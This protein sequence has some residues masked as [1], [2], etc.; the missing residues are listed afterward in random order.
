MPQS[1]PTRTTYSIVRNQTVV[2]FVNNGPIIRNPDKDLL[3]VASTYYINCCIKY[4]GWLWSD[5]HVD[6][7]ASQSFPF[8]G[9]FCGHY[10]C[11]SFIKYFQEPTRFELSGQERDGVPDDFC[12]GVLTVEGGNAT[13]TIHKKKHFGALHVL[14][15]GLRPYIFPKLSVLPG[16]FRFFFGGVGKQQVDGACVIDSTSLGFFSFLTSVTFPSSKK[17][18]GPP[19]QLGQLPKVTRWT[20]LSFNNGAILFRV[21]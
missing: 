2:Y 17:N 13:L 6:P 20:F 16:K 1:V 18:P 9:L 3:L 14:Y 15:A 21:Q 10:S 12:S 7:A 5:E 8:N 4:L 11:F 19:I